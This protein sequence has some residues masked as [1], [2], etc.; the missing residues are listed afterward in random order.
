MTKE[1]HLR[2]TIIEEIANSITH[3]IGFG[4]SVAGLTLLVVYASF[5]GDP[6]RIVA[7]AIY[8]TTLALLYLTSTLYHSITHTE[9]KSIFRRLDHSAIYLLIAG[10]YTPI[11]LITLRDS[12]VLYMLPLVWLMA[13]LGILV[14]VKYFHSSQKLSLL[15]YIGMGWM[16]LIAAK[17]LYENIPIQS[18]V[19]IIIGGLAYS[20]GVIFYTWKKLPFHHT[21]W[22]GFVMAGSLSHF[23]GML[24]I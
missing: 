24:Y 23:I 20:L 6:W 5:T 15:F 13:L 16:A 17:P 1:K 18:F 3:G 7:F 8:G 19:W 9:A 22:H 14:K 2:Q 4:L 11:I 21:I 12:W 10:T